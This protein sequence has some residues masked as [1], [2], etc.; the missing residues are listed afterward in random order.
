MKKLDKLLPKRWWQLIAVV[1]AIL[2]VALIGLRIWYGQNLSPVNSSDKT[3]VY[4]T[5]EQGSSLHEIALG[6]KKQSLIRSTSVF[7]Y[8][9]RTHE[10]Y[11]S[12]Q[13]GS[14]ALNRSLSGQEIVRKITHGEI[15]TNLV[16]VLPGKRLDQ[17]R[18]NFEA[19]GYTKAQ[20]N[21]AFDPATYGGL[22]AISS[23]PAGATLEGYMYPDSFQKDANTSASAIVKESLNE[24]NKYLTAD[25]VDG[26]KAQNLTIYQCITL[27][28]VVY[29]ESGDPKYEAMVAQV[30]LTRLKQ[31]M[32]LGSDVTAFYGAAIAG[33]TPSVT[34]DS[35][36]NTR[37]RA[38]LPP[39]P[40]SN[41]TADALIAV[42]HPAN[43]DYLFFVAGDD[44]I[45]HFSHTQAEHDAAIEKYCTK[46]CHQ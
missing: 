16:T 28:S 45:L 26:C 41:F 5:V 36:F 43:T 42:A 25:V 29:Q 27:A 17:I 10:L 40:I 12:L 37:L 23:L 31:G 9:V 34:Y 44:G 2:I 8:Y 35:A 20:I 19:A 13:A 14:Y 21:A 11:G 24:L 4:Y 15:S 33:Q 32:N 3:T 22:P 39:G 7:E 1:L 6:L 30:F 18:K 38:G 46:E